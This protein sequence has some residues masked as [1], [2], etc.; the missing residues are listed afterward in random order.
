MATLEMEAI[1]V[2][3][4]YFSET[5]DQAASAIGFSY[6]EIRR[7][8]GSAGDVS[9]IMMSLPGVAKVNDQS[10]NLIVRGGNPIENTFFIDN[11]EVPNI[12]HFPNQGSSGGPIG[13]INVDLIQDVHF[14]TGGFAAKYGDRLSSVMDI[15]FREGNRTEFDGQIDFNLAGFGGV[16]EGPLFHD[17]GSWLVSARRSYLDFV[18]GLFDVGSTIAPTYGDI[19][20]KIIYDPAQNH[21]LTLLFLHADDHNAPDRKTG[22]ENAMDH[23]G[24]QDLYQ[25]TAGINWRALWGKNGYSNTSVSITSSKYVENFYETSTGKFDIRNRTKEQ[26]WKFRN[27]NYFRLNNTHAVEFGMEAKHRKEEYDN[28]YAETTSVLGDTV[29]AFLLRQKLTANKMGFFINWATTFFHRFEAALGLRS[30]YFSYNENITVSPRISLSYQ[31]TPLT[32]LNASWGRFHQHLPLLLL[33]QYPVHK[34]LKDPSAIHMILGI[35]HMLTEDTKLTLE[36]YKKDYTCFPMDSAQ[37]GLFI[38]DY[39]YFDNYEKL[40]DNGRALS[41][42]IEIT[43]QK[44]LAKDFYGLISGSYFRSRYRGGDGTWRNRSYDNRFTFS[45]EGGYKPNRNWEFSLRWIYAGGV[46][47]TPFDVEKSKQNHRAVY[48]ENKINEMR[49][50]HYFSVNIRFDKRFHFTRSDLILYLSIWNATNRKNIANYFW[51]D[52]E[53]KQDKVYQW[54]LLPILGLEFE[55]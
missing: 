15:Q 39:S 14:Y 38:M 40:R 4:G 45:M 46:P 18:V 13:M 28:W 1:S 42:G 6:E 36:L 10:N 37:P 34:A 49:Y 43:I 54:P 52:R 26:V 48:D 55:F 20:G 33:S 53:Q 31:W 23:Y 22:E 41:Y 25:Q 8:P 5:N 7:A 30:D 3:A 35:E 12:N 24:N 44:K 11:I 27:S 32:S 29:P 9:R 2:S 47:Y 21:K 17:R 19:Q 50:P 16:G 51:N